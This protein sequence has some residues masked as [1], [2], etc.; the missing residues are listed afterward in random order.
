MAPPD[1]P[2][3]YVYCVKAGKKHHDLFTTIY[4]GENY[5][6]RCGLANPFQ[7]QRRARSRTP[8]LPGPYNE[9]VEVDDSPPHPVSPASQ[10][11]RDKPKPVSSAAI[12]YAQ[13]LP[14]AVSVPNGVTANTR[15]RQ[16]PF[17]PSSGPPHPQ[18]M[19]IASAASQ[20]IQ[21]TKSSTRKPTRQR[22]GYQWVHIS[23]LLMSLE[24]RYFNGLVVEVPETVLP[25]KDT[26]IKFSSADLL[27]WPSFTHT[28]FEHLHPLPSTVDPTNQELWKLSYASSFSGKKIVT[29]P[30]TDK[31]TTPSS[32]LTSG[33]F[34]NNQAG[35]LK[36]LVVL[37]STDVGDKQEP[38]TPLR[39][40]EYSTPA[41]DGKKRKVKQED[42]S[43]A[44][45]LKKRIKQER[46]INQG[47]GTK[48]REQVKQEKAVPASTYLNLAYED[49]NDILDNIVVKGDVVDLSESE[50]AVTDLMLDSVSDGEGDERDT[51][52]EDEVD[53]S[54]ETS[55]FK[56]FVCNQTEFLPIEILISAGKPAVGSHP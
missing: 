1:I 23:L 24:T 33:H 32:M 10:L 30:N 55:L 48:N 17:K 8:A 29:V 18:F 25:L 11:M 39:T 50:D 38:I 41:K 27:T 31:F 26:V 13:L 51:D 28:L 12:G 4:G 43:P 21:N 53:C 6:G 36:V 3:E 56:E 52:Q 20:A 54:S 2:P 22:T 5:C 34:S 35:Q 15:A 16:H 14:N 49:R 40:D 46:Q 47:N 45:G 37:T 42:S 9:V 7:S 19:A 44:P